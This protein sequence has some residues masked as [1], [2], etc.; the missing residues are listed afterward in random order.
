[1]LQTMIVSIVA[2]PFVLGLVAALGR[3]RLPTAL[4]ALL[5]PLFAVVVYLGI[6]GVPAFPPVRAAHKAP[7]VLA[8]GGVVFAAVAL[9][10]RRSA[11]ALAALLAALSVALPAWWLG[12][13]IL[14]NN[15][16]KATVVAV[17][18]VIATVGAFAAAST[19]ASTRAGGAVLPQA[20]FATAL[21]SA[22]VAILGGYMGMA[23]F[24]GGLAALAG[25]YVLVCYVR[26]LRGDAHAFALDGAGALAFAWVVFMG[27][28][29]TAILAPKASAAALIAVGLTL[30]AISLT[31]GLAARFSTIPAPLRPL[32]GGLIAAIPA[33]AGILIAGLQ[34]AG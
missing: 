4:F 29:F 32:T 18:A 2:I 17:L 1:M 15:G 5:V 20:I 8:L 16:M 3:T 6:E 24:N 12:S 34:F 22:L 14:A 25:G 30:P 11:P 9:V 19:A 21:A 10:V 33:L 7:Y 31:A 27:L 26:H 28:V 13:N 23:M